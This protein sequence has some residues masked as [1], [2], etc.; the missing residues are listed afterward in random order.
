MKIVTEEILDV[1][2]TVVPTTEPNSPSR[3]STHVEEIYKPE[4]TFLDSYKCPICAKG[5]QNSLV[6]NLCGH[7]VC[8][9]CFLTATEE[10]KTACPQCHIDY[11]IFTDLKG[12][13]HDYGYLGKTADTCNLELV[14]GNSIHSL[15][16]IRNHSCQDMKL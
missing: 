16:A 1:P 9:S 2:E 11:A 10:Q 7:Y 8:F 13:D 15:P 14:F 4:K 3:P 12:A 6:K 5:E